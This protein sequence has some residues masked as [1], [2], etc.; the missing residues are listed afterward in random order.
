MDAAAAT[1]IRIGTSLPSLPLCMAVLSQDQVITLAVQFVIDIISANLIV[2]HGQD[3][4]VSP[5][6]QNWQH[7]SQLYAKRC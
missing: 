3:S 1:I 7:G 5:D 4:F 2:G 6:A